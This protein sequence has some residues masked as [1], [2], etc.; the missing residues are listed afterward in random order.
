MSDSMAYREK[1]LL[2]QWCPSSD[3]LKEPQLSTTQWEGAA[4][5]I[6]A[7]VVQIAAEGQLNF[8]DLLRTLDHNRNP[9]NSHLIQFLLKKVTV[10]KSTGCFW[11]KCSSY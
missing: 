7:T 11:S 1:M 5:L 8:S 10:A 4:L 2:F 6:C 9:N 3:A